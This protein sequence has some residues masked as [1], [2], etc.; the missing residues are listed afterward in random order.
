[1]AKHRRDGKHDGG[2]AAGKG[3]TERERADLIPWLHCQIFSHRLSSNPVKV[4]LNHVFYMKDGQM[5]VIELEMVPDTI[6]VSERSRRVT[7][8]EQLGALGRNT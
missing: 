4:K 3:Y 7:F 6:Q 2:H 1:M 5:A 8:A